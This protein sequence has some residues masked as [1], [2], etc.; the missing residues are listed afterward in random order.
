MKLACF[1]EY[2]LEAA[3]FQAFNSDFSELTPNDFIE[4]E[5]LTKLNAVGLVVGANFGLVKKQRVTV[6]FSSF[7]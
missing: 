3:V 4:K 1:G 6:N 2:G 5:L 7:L